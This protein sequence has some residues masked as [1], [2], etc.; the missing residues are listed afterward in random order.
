[1]A[2]HG[3]LPSWSAAEG[4]LYWA[5][6]LAPAV[7]VLDPS[8]APR[9]IAK[10]ER[11]IEAM[12]LA[13]PQVERLAPEAIGAGFDTAPR[14]PDLAPLVE[15]YQPAL[16]IHGQTHEAC[17]YLIGQTRIVCNPRGYP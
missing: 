15:R 16:W 3:C 7:H 9:Q 11:P 13:A 8:G 12:A 10:L 2:F 5:D 1:M 17:D 14:A 6:R 4:V